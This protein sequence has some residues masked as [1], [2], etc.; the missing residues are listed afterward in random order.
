MM[1]S[2]WHNLRRRRAFLSYLPVSFCSISKNFWI[3]TS[4]PLTQRLCWL[5]SGLRPIPLCFVPLPMYLAP[6]MSFRS[7]IG[8]TV[9]SI[10]SAVQSTL[11]RVSYP[12]LQTK[13]TEQFRVINFKSLGNVAKVQLALSPPVTRAATQDSHR[14]QHLPSITAGPDVVE[15]NG[16]SESASDRDQHNA[17]FHD[18]T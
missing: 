2:A 18:K 7:K 14:H 13:S 12:H 4:R 8:S 9:S 11:H 6:F 3:A 15:K 17:N 5:Q 1:A 10:T 16:V